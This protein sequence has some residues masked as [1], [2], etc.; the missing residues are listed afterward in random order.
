MEAYRLAYLRNLNRYFFQENGV[1]FYA[2]H[3][4]Y[5]GESRK[6]PELVNKELRLCKHYQTKSTGLFQPEY[7][8]Q[9][10][11]YMISF[12]PHS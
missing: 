4:F 6:Y 2:T 12:S 9:F 8:L 1:R 7:V 11:I 3:F 5:V 10:V